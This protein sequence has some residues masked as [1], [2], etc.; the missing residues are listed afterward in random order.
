MA[1]EGYDSVTIDGIAYA[2]K[3]S[4]ATLYRR[5]PSKAELV[6][7]AVRD[8][9][10]NTILEDP[11]DSGTLRG[12][13]L[14]MLRLAARELVRDSD[15]VVA[16]LAAARRNDELMR[17]VSAQLR[18]PG[19]AVGRLTL[20]RSIARGELPPGTDTLLIAEVAMPMFLHRVIWRE[21]LDEAY[22]QHV[23]DDVLLRLLLPRAPR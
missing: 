3:A 15:L 6:V 2:A 20:E 14:A 7:N 18:Q 21:P 23:V 12:D 13:L 17:I 9:V 22:V 4:K 1:R 8:K 16:L 5:W 11:G 10:T 19:E